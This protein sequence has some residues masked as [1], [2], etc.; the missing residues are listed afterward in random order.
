[1]KVYY[2]LF[3]EERAEQLFAIPNRFTMM[4]TDT[5]QPIDGGRRA[6]MATFGSWWALFVTFGWINS[7]GVF[8]AYYEEN[9]LSDFSP[10]AI[11][12][13]ASTQ[14]CL[15][16]SGGLVFGK[17]FDSHGPRWLLIAGGFGHV[18]GLVMTS[19]STQYYQIFLAQAICS[20]VGA[21]CVYYA[22]LGSLATWFQKRRATAYGI[23]AS[24]S[25]VGGIVFPIMVSRLINQIGFGWTMRA[26]ALIVLI[27]VVV[28]AFTL[29][30]NRTHTP[31]AFS[32][33]AY[34]QPFKELQFAMLVASLTVFSF[35]LF[36]PFNFLVSEAQSRGMSAELANYTIAI[37]NAASIFGRIL[38]GLL[39]DRFGRFNLMIICTGMSGV[40][41]LALWLPGQSNAA[42]ICFAAV[43]GFFS[44]GYVSLTPALVAEIS[45]IQDIGLRT[46]SLFF[47]VSIAVLAGSPIGGALIDENGGS[48]SHLQIFAGSMMCAGSLLVLGVRLLLFTTGT[49]T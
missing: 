29:E 31:T 1:L 32:L 17:L 42:T 7:L 37:L 21:S 13:I 24:G 41:T 26:V 18:F 38:P 33:G 11:A 2:L 19:I 49:E 12:W 44:G 45:S 5:P 22:C 39:A 48:Y 20:A 4:S 16:Y 43:F 46:A 30:S 25:S 14:Q 23:A 8:Q 6:W 15:M 47:F 35:G 40:I 34:L 3:D 10:S 27:G 28:T 9:L 36:L